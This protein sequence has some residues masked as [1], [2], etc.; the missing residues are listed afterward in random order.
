M[1]A[2]DTTPR[3]R[4][5]RWRTAAAAVGVVGLVA[6]LGLVHPA[7]ASAAPDGTAW[8]SRLDASATTW[9]DVAYGNGLFVAVADSGT[10]RVMTSP[11]GINWTARTTGPAAATWNG[12]AYGNGHFV[13]VARSGANRIMTSTDGIN[14]T[15]HEAPGNRTWRDVTYGSAGFVAVAT[16][17][18]MVSTDNGAT[19]TEHSAATSNAWTAV[20]YGN[21]Q[22]VAVAETGN[23]DRA[24]YSTDG[25]SW[26]SS[27]TQGLNNTWQDVTFGN[28][29][30]VAVASSSETSPT[31]QVMCGEDPA[32]PAYPTDPRGWRTLNP[33]ANEAGLT[34]TG[35]TYGNGRFVAVS[36]TA[37]T[38]K[39]GY[40]VATSTD[41]L[42]WTSHPAAT[43][44]QWMSV[45][46]GQDKFVAVSSSATTDSVMTANDALLNQV[47]SP[48]DNTTLTN[49][50][51]LVP[52]SGTAPGTINRIDII[53]NTQARIDS[54]PGPPALGTR[55]G[56][57]GMN[58]ADKSLTLARSN[59]I[60]V[61][62]A[63][64]QN[65]GS[66]TVLG[67]PAKDC[68]RP[69]PMGPLKSGQSLVF[70]ANIQVN[71]VWTGNNTS[72][73]TVTRP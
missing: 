14:W 48:T 35:V 28:G 61:D 7:T 58:W 72:N 16:A 67:M 11:D 71:G 68:P 8:T 38:G 46:Y 2:Q 27:Q 47:K 39:P 34:F 9:T 45:A 19:W 57:W 6:G 62:L 73:F 37:T 49:T 52:R 55:W 31:R 1:T 22:Y 63:T 70:R 26:T 21:G 56:I 13:A 3:S 29:R 12:I 25:T 40:N 54:I 5:A 36:D 15:Q 59:A 64:Y 10:N 65:A 23:K 44:Q 69:L 53:Y 18:T 20:T 43:E 4:A 60:P 41:C 50:L 51:Q 17:K 32:V 42:N 33:V 66:C 24:M 30:F